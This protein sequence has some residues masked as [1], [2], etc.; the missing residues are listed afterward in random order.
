MSDSADRL[1]LHQDWL[2]SN[3]RRGQRLIEPGSR[4]SSLTMVGANL[5]E[6]VLSGARITQTNLDD[7]DFSE[8]ILDE[9]V[10]YDS[11]LRRAKL[12]SATGLSAGA[13]AGTDLTDAALPP[14]VSDFP[15]LS[16]AH[17]IASQSQTLTIL[18][19]AACFYCWITVGSTTDSSLVLN[20]GAARL[21]VAGVDIPTTT[22]FTV[23]PGLLLSLHVYL[24]LTLQR[25]WECLA[26][27]PA[28][29]PD[30]QRLD[31]RAFS[32]LLADV[33]RSETPQL[34]KS[35]VAFGRSGQALSKL[36]IWWLVPL[37]IAVLLQR[38]L[39]SQHVGL[40]VS[41][42]AVLSCAVVFTWHCRRLMRRTLRR[43]EHVAVRLR[44]RI[45]AILTTVSTTVLLTAVLAWWGSLAF[46]TLEVSKPY[47]EYS[48]PEGFIASSQ[49]SIENASPALAARIAAYSLGKR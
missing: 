44:R 27:L 49:R 48:G 8:A 28:K 15:L 10:L 12:A 38:S 37:T 30:G 3:G 42:T 46:S 43:R 25:L 2:S 22:F 23:A 9:A 21:P 40:L 41:Q 7:A 24:H 20:T 4:L 45:G 16:T 34:R 17:E 26:W 32:W 47:F 18:I 11:S 29:F 31:R 19:V 5:R 1:A 35:E 36:L 13:L 39:P 14:Q 33:I 6:A